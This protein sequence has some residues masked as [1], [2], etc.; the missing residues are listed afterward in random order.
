[1]S[2]IST[3]FDYF[4][5]QLGILYPT[6]KR[7]PNPYS[8]VDNKDNL[9]SDSYGIRTSGHTFIED[10]LC[11]KFTQEHTFRITFTRELTRLESDVVKVDTIIKNLEEDMFTLESFFYD[12]DNSGSPDTIEQVQLGS[13]DPIGFIYSGKNNFLF[14]ETSL[15]VRINEAF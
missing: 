13:A 3:A 10:Q 8:L 15:F 4:V 6:K 12:V 5:T 2:K 14:Y 11:D 9:L 7:I 1:M